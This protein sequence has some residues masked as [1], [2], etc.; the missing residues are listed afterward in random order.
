M[1]Y[2]TNNQ[3]SQTFLN[4]CMG[5][6]NKLK[7]KSDSIKII[8]QTNQIIPIDHQYQYY[9]MNN[10]LTLFNQP[11][12]NQQLINQYLSKE[13]SDCLIN[14]VKHRIFKN[15]HE[16]NYI[17][18]H[19][20]FY[21]QL[22]QCLIEYHNP[23]IKL[24]TFFQKYVHNMFIAPPIQNWI[25]NNCDTLLTIHFIV[26]QIPVQLDILYPKRQRISIKAIIQV[27][28]QSLTTLMNL[29]RIKL[30]HKLHL[31]YIP[32]KF[33]KKINFYRPNYLIDKFLKNQIHKDSNLKYNYQYFNNPISSLNVN[34]GVTVSEGN[35]QPLFISIWRAEEF[36][37]VLIHELIHYYELEK[38]SDFK[39]PIQI[40]ISNNYPH[41]SKELYTELQ[42]WLVFTLINATN[43]KI[44]KI[45]D[46]E[47]LLNEEK[48]HA[49]INIYLILKHYKINQFNQL[50]NP[51]IV[52]PSGELIINANS[53]VLYYY[54]IKGC[55]LFHGGAF[56]EKLLIPEQICQQCRQSIH[57]QM[58]SHIQT[59]PKNTLLSTCIDQMIQLDY[60]FPDSLNMMKYNVPIIPFT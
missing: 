56:M 21:R 37:K 2:L 15:L 25:F 22:T 17:L 29:Y 8:S 47:K 38:G 13:Q 51:L 31:I 55:L 58:I 53:S 20:P 46:L 7:N 18:A 4:Q 19:L 6:I 26:D 59:I 30:K 43:L 49:I 41:Y 5:L 45:Q 32:T 34:S 11:Q 44:N 14:L 27:V 28:S 23:N 42:T 9:L 10:A 16:F 60:N 1:N 52:N 57:Q 36:N 54:I 40:N 24:P 3:W 39:L 50:F 48:Y 12:L 35:H 33:K